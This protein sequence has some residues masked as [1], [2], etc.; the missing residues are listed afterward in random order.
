MFRDLAFHS[1]QMSSVVAAESL[2]RITSNAT[3]LQPVEITIAAAIVE[4]LTEDA[5]TNPNVCVVPT[6]TQLH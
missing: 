2:E 5:A 4:Q 3:E 1:I 6:V